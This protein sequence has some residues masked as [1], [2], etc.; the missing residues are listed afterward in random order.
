MYMF[1]I[2]R[3]LSELDALNKVLGFVADMRPSSFRML[4]IELNDFSQSV[5]SGQN[6]GYL[7]SLFLLSPLSGRVILAIWQ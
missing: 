2:Y 4:L 3:G 7:K 1:F 5:G 6:I